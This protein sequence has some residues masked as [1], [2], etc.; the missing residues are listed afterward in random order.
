MIH[1]K[2]PFNSNELYH[3]HQTIIRFTLCVSFKGDAARAI[4]VCCVVATALY[5][6]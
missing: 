1:I 5:C 6:V 2:D 4:P 3:H